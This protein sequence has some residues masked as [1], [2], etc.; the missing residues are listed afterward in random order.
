MDQRKINQLALGLWASFLVLLSIFFDV[1]IAQSVIKES[2]DTFDPR[3]FSSVTLLAFLDL[4]MMVIA[5]IELLARKQWG[6][7]LFVVAA[8]SWGL[9]PP[10]S[11]SAVWHVPGTG[12]PVN[13]VNFYVG[14]LVPC[15]PCLAILAW[16]SGRA[17]V[18]QKT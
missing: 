5:L 9:L 13:W 15:L 12:P 18:F 1:L 6:F 16:L 4:L 11:Y 3:D 10:M 14:F 17:R 7:W 2:A 8:L